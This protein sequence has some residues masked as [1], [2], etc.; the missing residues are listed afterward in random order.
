MRCL[1]SACNAILLPAK[2]AKQ[3]NTFPYATDKF[4]INCED[5]HLTI[6]LITRHSVCRYANDERIFFTRKSIYVTTI[7]NVAKK[8]KKLEWEFQ[9]P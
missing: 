7:S 5:M 2:R 6:E 4:E 1:T 8:N 9:F 3:Y